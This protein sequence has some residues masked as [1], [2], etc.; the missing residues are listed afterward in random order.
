MSVAEVAVAPF[1][2]EK[3]SGGALRAV[4]DSCLERLVQELAAEGV[5][6]VRQPELS[7]KKLQL[8]RPVPLAVLG[9]VDR[10][11]GLIQAE[12]LVVEVDSGEE[13]RSYFNADKDPD[14]V[15]NLGAAAAKR[16]AQL[17]RERKSAP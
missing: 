16:I 4:A 7:Q 1:V 9:R 5:A 13:L 6:V 17:I 3:D 10:A 2:V 8:V 12:L 15:A 14:A 11:Q